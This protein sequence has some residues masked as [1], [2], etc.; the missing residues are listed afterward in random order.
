MLSRLYVDPLLNRLYA[1]PPLNRLYVD[2]MLRRLYAEKTTA[3]K[4]SEPLLSH[5]LSFV[6]KSLY[7]S[8]QHPLRNLLPR[9]WVVHDVQVCPRPWAVR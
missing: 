2:P 4:S 9:P 5:D 7:D 8:R 6:S 3:I 1:D